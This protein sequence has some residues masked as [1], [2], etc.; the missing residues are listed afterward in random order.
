MLSSVAI[1]GGVA[2]G[3]RLLLLVRL[4]DLVLVFL[5]FGAIVLLDIVGDDAVSHT[6]DVEE[7]EEVQGLKGDEEGGGNGL[8]EG[9][10]VLLGL[11]VELEGADRTELGEERPNDLEINKV[12]E[13][14][15]GSH[16][17]AVEGDGNGVIEVVESLG[18]REEKVG[19]IVGDVDGDANVGEVK[20]VAEEDERERDNVVAD[21][22][23]EVL[24][25]LLHA[26]N[27]DNGLLGPVGGLKEVIEFEETALGAVGKRLVHAARVEVPDGCLAHD[28][29]AQRSK[30][31]EVDSGVSL[32][33]EA[34]LLSL[35]ETGAA[36]YGTQHLLHD[37]LAGEG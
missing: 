26:E 21:K 29:H 23:L 22:L 35:P 28:V 36:G 20:A 32:L 11:P 13:V 6:E 17:D 31:G 14:D 16:E 12:A 4:F 34:S 1:F 2:V 8:A 18:G 24:A 10:L 5:V 30:D 3:Q 19:N 37:E 27:E 15:P 25:G 7:P 33:H 9:T